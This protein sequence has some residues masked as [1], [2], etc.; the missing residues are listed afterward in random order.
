[1]HKIKWGDLQYVMA[2]ASEGSVS[3]AAKRLNVN[4]STVLRRLDAFEFRHKVK[5]FK[6]AAT[7]YSLTSKGEKLLSS[8]LKMEQQVQHIERLITS[9]EFD[10]EGWLQLTTTDVI[11][12]RLLEPHLRTFQKTYDKIQLSI[13]LTPK[14]LDLASL[15]SDIAI[16]SINE[17][18]EGAA[19]EVLIYSPIYCYASHNYLRTQPDKL[20]INELDWLLPSMVNM[21][22]PVWQQALGSVPDQQIKVK[23]DSFDTLLGYAEN[24]FGV[25]LLPDFLGDTS[26]QLTRLDLIPNLPNTTIWIMAH[27]DLFKSRKIAVFVKHLKNSLA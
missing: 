10:L 1:M 4:H 9:H 25:A 18:P 7:G 8:S 5:L 11:F 22:N 14:S 12:K 6:R 19:G 26:D 15:E 23:A 24:D 13:S 21:K 20:S 27:E 16:R 17:L 2:V 3:G